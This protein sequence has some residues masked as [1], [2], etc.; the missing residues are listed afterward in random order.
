[1]WAMA[2]MCW[3]QSLCSDSD[4]KKV[5]KRDRKWLKAMRINECQAD[6]NAETYR[7]LCCS[8]TNVSVMLLNQYIKLTAVCVLSYAHSVQWEVVSVPQCTETMKKKSENGTNHCLYRTN[9][10]RIA[11]WIWSTEMERK[12]RLE[13]MKQNLITYAMW[14]ITC[15]ITML[16]CMLKPVKADK[17]DIL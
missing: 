7:A 11:F 15:F 12:R 2:V 1:M 5:Q 16:K 9:M 6:T 4:W 13:M 14:K 3:V 10:K 8:H 17:T